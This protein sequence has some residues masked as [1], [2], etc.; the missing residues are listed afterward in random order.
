MLQFIQ[1]TFNTIFHFL[2]ASYFQQVP[3]PDLSSRAMKKIVILGGSYAG[4][5]TAHRVLKQAGKTAPFKI[6]LVSPNTHFYWSMASTRGMVPGQISDED[7]F[8]PIAEGFKQYTVY[9]QLPPFFPLA[10][11][12]AL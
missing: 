6:T 8:R 12:D 10:N 1:S 9:S 4:I 11:F 7:L 5:S 2:T 3:D